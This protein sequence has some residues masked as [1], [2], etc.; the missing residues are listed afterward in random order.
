MMS[1]ALC[2]GGGARAFES[3]GS[4][5]HKESIMVISSCAFKVEF[6][7]QNRSN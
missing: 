2:I 4:S 3:G 5:A 6:G 1:E 7:M